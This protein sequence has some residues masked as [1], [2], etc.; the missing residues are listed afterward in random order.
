MPDRARYRRKPI[1]ELSPEREQIINEVLSD[2]KRTAARLQELRDRRNALFREM[3]AEGWS[4]AALAKIAKISPQRMSKVVH[5]TPIK[6]R[7]AR[8]RLDDWL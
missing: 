7:P 3:Y 6:G 8:R 5:P 4:I 2:C 1:M